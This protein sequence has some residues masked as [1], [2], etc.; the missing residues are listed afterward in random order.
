MIE[1]ML[2]AAFAV[3]FVWSVGLIAF[4]VAVA[5]LEIRGEDQ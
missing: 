1:L 5:R 4:L 2:V 3:L